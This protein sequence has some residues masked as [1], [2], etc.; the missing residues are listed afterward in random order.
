MP[1]YYTG[2]AEG[3]RALALEE[4]EKENTAIITELT[5]MLC[6]TLTEME[7]HLEPEQVEAILS[8]RTQ[9]WWRKHKKIDAKRNRKPK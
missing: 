1:C 3:D 2:S 9:T 8:K 5:Q 6:S 7:G 4:A